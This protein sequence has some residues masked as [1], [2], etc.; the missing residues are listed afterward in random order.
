MR[1]KGKVAPPLSVEEQIAHGNEAET[2]LQSPL[3]N[4]ACDWLEDKYLSSWVDSKSDEDAFREDCYY[5]LKAL[6]SIKEEIQFIINNA[7]LAK[8]QT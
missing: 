6:Y 7:K 8:Q 5:S 3:F 4:H 1:K 2:L